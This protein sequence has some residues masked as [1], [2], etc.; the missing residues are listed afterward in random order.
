MF[1]GP[2]NTHPQWIKLSHIVFNKAE[3]DPPTGSSCMFHACELPTS[4]PKPA[5][6]VIEGQR[7]RNEKNKALEAPIALCFAYSLCSK[8]EQKLNKLTLTI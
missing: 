1:L 3:F 2:A 4:P 6:G 5:E 8:V 7:N